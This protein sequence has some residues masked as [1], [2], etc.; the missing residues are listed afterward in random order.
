[1]SRFWTDFS[2]FESTHIL[3]VDFF[4]W[5]FYVENRK[6]ETWNQTLKIER[7]VHLF[8]Q[9]VRIS[10]R[11]TGIKINVKDC[12]YA[13]RQPP[14]IVFRWY[15]SSIVSSKHS[16]NCKSIEFHVLFY[17][18][19]FINEKCDFNKL[20]KK[21]IVNI[22]LFFTCIAL[23]DSHDHNQSNMPDNIICASRLPSHRIHPIVISHEFLNVHLKI[24]QIWKFGNLWANLSRIQ[25]FEN[26]KFW[27]RR[28]LRFDVQRKL[29][30]L[31]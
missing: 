26:S 14:F 15:L 17:L 29:S 1:M 22:W 10:L 28:S 6:F 5:N 23:N 8:R 25:E 30:M 4:F 24:L 20:E 12:W 18:M 21:K 11:K 19:H 13:V 3:V 31:T 27:E 2:N 7:V 16:K 9:I